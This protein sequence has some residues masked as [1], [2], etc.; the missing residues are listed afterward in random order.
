MPFNFTKKG[1]EI[2]FVALLVGNIV[3]QTEA[4]T[5]NCEQALP[6]FGTV[7]FEELQEFWDED[8]E[9]PVQCICIQHL[10]RVFTDLLEGTKRSLK[11]T[12]FEHNIVFTSTNI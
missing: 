5:I 2:E 7:V 11:H 3:M 10:S 12:K 4:D 8:I 6:D 9:G 1:K